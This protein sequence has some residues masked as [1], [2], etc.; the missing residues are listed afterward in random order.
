MRNARRSLEAAVLLDND[1]RC[2]G[3]EDSFL[4]DEISER[5]DD[6]TERPS[7]RGVALRELEVGEL[8]CAFEKSD[9]SLVHSILPA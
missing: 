6:R 9:L 1:G 7:F 8:S 3:I 5:I 4:D 2:G